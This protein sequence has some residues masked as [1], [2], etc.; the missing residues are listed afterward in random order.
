M[1]EGIVKAILEDAQYRVIDSGIEK[2][3]RELA[4]LSP[5]QYAGLAYPDAM[6]QLPDFTVMNVEQTEKFLVEVKYRS[7]WDSSLFVEITEQVKVYGELVL[8]SINANPPNHKGLFLPST[9]LRCC[10]VK[11]ADEKLMLQL[12]FKNHLKENHY[13]KPLDE[14]NEDSLWW[15]MSELDRVFTGLKSDDLDSRK[16]LDSA[17]KALSGI[18][19]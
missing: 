5:M 3:V 14:V 13:W 19:N 12:K 2:V 17:I 9:Y 18:L 1:S 10:R 6:R 16:S 8:V 11:Y 15:G 4:C 7:Q